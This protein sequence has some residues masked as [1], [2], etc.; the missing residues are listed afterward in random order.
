MRVAI[1]LFNLGGPDNLKAVQPFLFN[2]F[3]DPAII[4]VPNPIRWLLAKLIS[5]RRAPTAKAIY[6]NIGGSSPL[7]KQTIDQAQALEKLF[8]KEDQVKAFIAMRYW[9]PLS[10]ETAKAVKAFGADRI[11]LLPLYPQ[12]STTTTGSSITEWQSASEK[13]G[14][15]APTSAICCYPQESGFIETI[16]NNTR[17]II[18]EASKSGTPRI[19]FSAHG[20]PQKIVDAGDPY[21]DHIEMTA[22]EVVKKLNIKNLDWIVC[23]QSRVGPLKWIGPSTDDEIARAAKDGVPIVIVPIAF[24]SEHSETLVELD[25]EYRELATSLGVPAYYRVATAYITPQFINGLQRLV[26][27]AL[28][29]IKETDSSEAL[30]IFSGAGCKIC[31]S[32]GSQCRNN[33]KD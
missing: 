4:G 13:A 29:T 25:I 21:P 33:E 14:I 10:D 27:K 26:K 18:V 1:V 22:A 6:N 32:N 5:F 7:L 23:Y 3:N 2:L 30:Y 28:E 17:N 16:V 12:Y 8:D 20:L 9:H 15:T 19:L 31:S 24:V 11:V